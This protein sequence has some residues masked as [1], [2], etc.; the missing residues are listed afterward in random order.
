MKVATW[1]LSNLNMTIVLNFK[2]DK[3]KRFGL[4]LFGVS[5]PYFLGVEKLNKF[6]LLNSIFLLL[7]NR[8][9][10]LQTSLFQNV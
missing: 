6:K 10:K 3:F 5:K 4:D 8:A 1:N 9:L 7:E 2:L